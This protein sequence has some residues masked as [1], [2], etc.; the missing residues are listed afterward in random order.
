MQSTWNSSSIV[1]SFLESKRILS[2]HDHQKLL[3]KGRLRVESNQC[4]VHLSLMGQLKH[5]PPESYQLLCWSFSRAGKLHKHTLFCKHRTKN[6]NHRSDPAD[7]SHITWHRNWFEKSCAGAPRIP[8][9]TK[10]HPDSSPTYFTSALQVHVRRPICYHLP[11]IRFAWHSF[12][13]PTVKIAHQILRR[14]LLH[15][16]SKVT[17]MCMHALQTI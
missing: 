7:T 2:S 11:M 3:D 17:P 6:L 12:H 1:L 8:P 14:F 9:S 16:M 13:Y 10:P 15:H 4:E 5:R